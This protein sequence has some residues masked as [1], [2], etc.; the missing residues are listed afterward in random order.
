MFIY[1]I[2]TFACVRSN[3]SEQTKRD[4][5][6]PL[7]NSTGS[8]VCS[9]DRCNRFVAL[10]F[11]SV[12][13]LFWQSWAPSFSIFFLSFIFSWF[14]PLDCHLC[15][16]RIC[17]KLGCAWLHYLQP[18]ISSGRR[19]FSCRRA[20]TLDSHFIVWTNSPEQVN[21]QFSFFIF[22]FLIKNDLL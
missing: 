15:P 7:G 16:V 11:F 20:R 18:Q 2:H 8:I 10:L 5:V 14:G 13:S 19:Q 12:F 6:S 17:T 3:K 22:I 9:A 21:F 4:F 1:F